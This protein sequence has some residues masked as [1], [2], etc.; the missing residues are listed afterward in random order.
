MEQKMTNEQ[1]L[2]Y[3]Q[4]RGCIALATIAKDVKTHG[5]MGFGKA[6]VG[7]ATRV[8]PDY[9]PKNPIFDDL[10]EAITDLVGAIVVVTGELP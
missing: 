3:L 7:Y 1:A 10:T 2:A 6:V 8:H 9:D 5:I 4:E